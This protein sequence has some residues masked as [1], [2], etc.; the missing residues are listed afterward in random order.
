MATIVQEEPDF[1]QIEKDI[2]EKNQD[3]KLRNL[4]KKHG[5][6]PQTDKSITSIKSIIQEDDLDE[7]EPDIG[8]YGATLKAL[9]YDDEWNFSGFLEKQELKSRDKW[10]HDSMSDPFGIEHIMNTTP[11]NTKASYTD[12]ESLEDND[13]IVEKIEVM[14]GEFEHV[15]STVEDLKSEIEDLRNTVLEMMQLIRNA[16]S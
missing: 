9:E 14:Q 1:D 16:T 6:T 15:A 5:L 10:V 8:T 2:R 11:K 3:R 4:E 12:V 7:Y 13:E